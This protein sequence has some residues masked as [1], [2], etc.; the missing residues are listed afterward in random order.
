MGTEINHITGF[1]PLIGDA[2]DA[3]TTI[4]LPDL[5]LELELATE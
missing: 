5:E 3:A 4:G 2:C 1:E